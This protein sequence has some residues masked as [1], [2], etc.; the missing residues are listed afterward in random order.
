VKLTETFLR[1]T[2][3]GQEEEGCQEGGRCEEVDEEGRQEE[4]EVALGTMPR[5]PR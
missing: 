1:R 5:E 4:E 3:C 2:N